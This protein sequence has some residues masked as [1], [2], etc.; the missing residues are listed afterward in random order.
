MYT[1]PQDALAG[2][3][4][5]RIW[6]RRR[7]ADRELHARRFQ[8]R[9]G[10]PRPRSVPSI[11]ASTA[12]RSTRPKANSRPRSKSRCA[13][14]RR[15]ETTV[16]M[17]AGSLAAPF[18]AR[19]VSGPSS[20]AAPPACSPRTRPARSGALGR[21][22]TFADNRAAY[23]AARRALPFLNCSAGIRTPPWG[24]K[25]IPALVLAASRGNLDPLAQAGG[26]SHKCFIDIAGQPML[27]RVVEGGDAMRPGRPHDR[28]DRAGEHRGGA[29][30]SSPVCPAPR[31]SNLWRAARIS[32]PA[33]SAIASPELLPADH[34]HRR[35]CASHRRDGPLLLRRARRRQRRRRPRPH[36]GAAMSSTSI[37]KGIAPSTAS[38][39][40]P[41]RAATSTPCSRRAASTAPQVFNSG[42]QF[43]KKPKRLIGAFGLAAFL[44][45]KSRLFTLST[46]L[47]A[48]SRDGRRQDR[49]DPDAVRR[50]A[51]R[52]RP[53]AG[54]GTRQ[55]HRPRTRS[56]LTCVLHLAN[57]VPSPPKIRLNAN[58]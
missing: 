4:L 29:R 34:H 20:T 49:A 40:A 26:V 43:G 56:G 41:S 1:D 9:G 12:I 52:R 11:P 54:L 5:A 13:D 45:Y 53:D 50:R 25:A 19:P 38:A 46:V 22:A 23:G 18:T 15:F 14:G 10:L 35:Q 31:R 24:T 28:R 3:I 51:D 44:L 39:T 57:S 6:R 17:P 33:S 42:G 36:P 55:S 30:R 2:Q 7:A 27:R 47:K 58:S 16:P 21:F 8:R 48:L 32:A 37:P